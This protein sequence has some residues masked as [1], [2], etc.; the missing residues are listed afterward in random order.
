[1]LID[2]LFKKHHFFLMEKMITMVDLLLV[3]LKENLVEE[4]AGKGFN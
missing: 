2:I 3:E 4:I 1:M